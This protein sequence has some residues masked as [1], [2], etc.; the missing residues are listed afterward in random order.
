[1]VR[2]FFWEQRLFAEQSFGHVSMYVGGEYIG[3]TPPVGGYISWWPQ[4]RWHIVSP[5]VENRPYDEDVN[6]EHRPPSPP[7]TLEGLNEEAIIKWW[8]D[9][10]AAGHRW[11]LYDQ[12][13]AQTVADA[14]RAG[15]GDKFVHGV[16]G[17]WRSW[18]VVW[19]PHDVLLFA[20]EIQHGLNGAASP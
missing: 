3:Q 20:L 7:L 18:N 5:A 13:C 17:W 16:S 6:A 4:Q 2:I 12:S 11:E 15:G 10:K 8:A 1:M 19:S 14:L 9:F